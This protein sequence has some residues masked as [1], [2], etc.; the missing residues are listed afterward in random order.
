MDLVVVQNVRTKL[1]T[2]NNEKQLKSKKRMSTG[3]DSDKN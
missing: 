3:N 1:A 2:E